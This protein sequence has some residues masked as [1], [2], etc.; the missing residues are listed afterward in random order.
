[1]FK[2]KR[3][4]HLT[5]VVDDLAVVDQWY[6]DVFSVNRF[7]HG[8]EEL[9]GRHA[10]LIAIG[11][12][13]LEPMMPAPVES[14]KNPSVKKFH[15]R[16][17]EHLHSIAWYVDDVQ[18]I[19]TRLDQENFRLFNIVGK[20]VKPPHSATAVWTHPRETSGQLEFAVY[21]DFIPDPRM[22]PGWSSAAW[23]EHPL[24]LEGASSIGVVID[25][26]SRAKWFY[27][28]VLGGSLIHEEKIAGRKRSAFVAIGEDTVVELAEPLSPECPEGRELERN[29]EGI[30]SLIFKTNDL[31]RARE[32]LRSKQH[33]PEQDGADTIVLGLDQAYGMLMGFTQRELPN[34]PR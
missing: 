33:R 13:V 4:F 26:M 32:F 25:D 1:M 11:D 16:F 5:Q 31:G 19:S 23:R 8:Y 12:V 27:C 28:E 34:D 17:G 15:D 14:L 6:D 21:G 30:F 10:S 24:G 2:I 22:E 20:P 7:Y 29:G 18:A 3:L 9:A